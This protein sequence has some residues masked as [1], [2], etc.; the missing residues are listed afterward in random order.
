MNMQKF[1]IRFIRFH[2]ADGGSLT[3]EL[4]NEGARDRLY[5]HITADL[6][7][8]QQRIG[9]LERDIE[10][11]GEWIHRYGN[12]ADEYDERIATLT[13]DLATANERIANLV[14]RLAL[15]EAVNKELGHTAYKLTAERDALR[16]ALRPF[17]DAWRNADP[18]SKS[19]A[20]HV[21][22]LDSSH[23]KQ[24]AALLGDGDKAQEGDDE[25]ETG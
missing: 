24:A 3:A 7:T 19:W 5:D 15:S 23:F 1:G 10:D 9:E 22:R 11:K 6:A 18:V 21:T 4:D 17:A 12:E 25:K 16:A 13:A 8:A 20:E 2:E 14:A